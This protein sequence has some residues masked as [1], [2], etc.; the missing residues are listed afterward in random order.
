M[1]SESSQMMMEQLLELVNEMLS[2]DVLIDH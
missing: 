1:V 2:A